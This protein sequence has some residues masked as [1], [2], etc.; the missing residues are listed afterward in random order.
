MTD[1]PESHACDDHY[2]AAI[3][4]SCDALITLQLIRASATSSSDQIADIEGQ[5]TRA[6]Q[7]LQRTVAELRLAQAERRSAF[8]IDFVLGTDVGDCGV[9]SGRT[10]STPRRT[11]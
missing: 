9:E 10:Q 2:E 8:V 1:L 3:E 4:A 6:I 7:S 11:A 5:I